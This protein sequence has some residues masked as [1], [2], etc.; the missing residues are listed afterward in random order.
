MLPKLVLVNQPHL[1]KC[2]VGLF[3]YP[4]VILLILDIH[5]SGILACWTKQPSCF[6]LPSVAR[7]SSELMIASIDGTG[8]SLAVVR[9][10]KPTGLE[11]RTVQFIIFRSNLLFV[12]YE[13]VPDCFPS[14]LSAYS[15]W[16]DFDLSKTKNWDVKRTTPHSPAR[17]LK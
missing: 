9:A 3:H 17:S 1:A 11:N 8:S 10:H 13:V 12:F 15:N 7:T 16:V 2:Q 6:W 14:C 4:M 5:S